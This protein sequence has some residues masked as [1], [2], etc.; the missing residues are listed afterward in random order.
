[1]EVCPNAEFIELLHQQYEKLRLQIQKEHDAL[2]VEHPY[3]SRLLYSPIPPTFAI[4]VC[5]GLAFLLPTL[6]AYLL[7]MHWIG[8][9]LWL[10]VGVFMAPWS[11]LRRIDAVWSQSQ[12]AVK[13]YYALNLSSVLY[14][15]LIAVP[16]SSGKTVQREW[17]EEQLDALRRDFV[18]TRHYAAD[19]GSE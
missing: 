1:M 5:I 14:A 3:V 12:V 10:I 6:G 4:R 19:S 7:E 13:V 8:V 11:L 9:A 17:I 18:V 2:I 15:A 16:L